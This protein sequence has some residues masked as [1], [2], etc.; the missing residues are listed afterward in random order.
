MKLLIIEDEFHAAQ[1]LKKLIKQIL[2]E[3]TILD[4][5]DSVE[6]SV[7]WFKANVHP[8]LIF[9]DVQLAD[10]LSF[11]IFKEVDVLA[12]IIFTTAFDQYS[13]RAFKVNSIDYLLKPI[14]EQELETAVQK[15]QNIN[16]QS[17]NSGLNELSKFI[18]NIELT[19]A[20]KERFLIK[21]KDKYAFLLSDDI[22]FFFSEDSITFLISN[23]GKR[24]IY[25]A[26]LN[27]LESEVNPAKFFRINRKQLLHIN[28]IEQISVHFNNRLKL[29]I[30]HGEEMETLV[31]RDKV[32][33]F[34]DWLNA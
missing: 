10:D 32:P 12:P 17:Q 25:D 3:S 23:N 6:D 5:I 21:Q 2:P 18:R 20:C 13:L 19:K 26:T 16:R 11:S 22:S 27:Q 34:K 29:K 14:D 28:A 15:F 4:L 1:R 7:S 33:M 8:D 24:Y 9:M 30:K 31:S